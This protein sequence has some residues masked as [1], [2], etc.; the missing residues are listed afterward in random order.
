MLIVHHL[1]NS[2]SQRVIW[3]LEELGLPYEIV[4][5]PHPVDS[6]RSS[7][8]LSKIHPLGKAP[9]LSDG[10]ITVAETGA[11]F[12]YLMDRCPGYLA[13]RSI[14]LLEVLLGGLVH[15]LSGNEVGICGPG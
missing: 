11:I 12:E 4:V 1:E 14:H 5:Q 13:A 15:A 2:R 3:L 6:R 10:G 8:S 7:E 9:V